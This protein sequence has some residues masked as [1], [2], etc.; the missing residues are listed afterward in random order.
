MPRT[1]LGTLVPRF[2]PTVR[3]HASCA[4]SGNVGAGFLTPTGTR[5][6]LGGP[7]PR[8]I[9][10]VMRGRC[11]P[12]PD[13]MSE[14]ASPD[15]DARR[16]VPGNL[17]GRGGQGVLP[18]LGT[19]SGGVRRVH[20]HDADV[21]LGGHRH[22]PGAEFRGRET[23][24][25]TAETLVSAVL[26]PAQRAEDFPVSSRLRTAHEAA[27]CPSPCWDRSARSPAASEPRNLP[28]SASTTASASDIR[29]RSRTA[30][31]EGP[32]TTNGAVNS[33]S[34]PTRSPHPAED[35]SRWSTSIT[36]NGHPFDLGTSVLILKGES[37]HAS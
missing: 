13:R 25:Q 24:D 26:L 37:E 21:L 2:R 27:S 14:G 12:S 18:V 4:R 7:M 15:R 20:R 5:G 32:G 35:P 16:I 22:Q 8:T 6:G 29:S 11:R 9:A 31:P 34:L 33:L 30:T 3:W 17:A 23:G 1:V 10:L 28:T 19:P 36:R